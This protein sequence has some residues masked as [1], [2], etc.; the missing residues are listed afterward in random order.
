VHRHCEEGF[1]PSLPRAKRGGSNL[2]YGFGFGSV[3]P[4]TRHSNL[5]KIAPAPSLRA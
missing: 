2:G 3:I 1:S 5:A 4:G